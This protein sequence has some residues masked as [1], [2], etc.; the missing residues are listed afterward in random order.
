MGGSEGPVISEARRKELLDRVKRRTAT[1]GQRI[2]ETI[3]IDGQPFELREFVMETKS[4]GAI[5]PAKRESVRTVR[6][7]LKRERER[8]RKRLETAELTEAAAIE[9]ADSILG[10]ERALTALGNLSEPDFEGQSKQAQV[11]GT[12]RWI[13]FVDQLTD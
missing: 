5:P 10:L 6:N 11:N 7:T 4:Q 8:R 9:L 2:P 1:I 12:R 3:E 13:D